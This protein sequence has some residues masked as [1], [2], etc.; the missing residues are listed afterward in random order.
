ML[1]HT[2]L[3]NRERGQARRPAPVPSDLRGRVMASWLMGL[4]ARPLAA[5]SV[6]TLADLGSLALAFAALA[7]ALAL[8]TLMSRPAMLR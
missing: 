8:V 7:V 3:S 2:M 1:F 4:G 6:C 5:A